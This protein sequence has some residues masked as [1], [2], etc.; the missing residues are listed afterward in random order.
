MTGN[1]SGAGNKH[2][3]AHNE[4]PPPAAAAAEELS[5]ERSAM[6]AASPAAA[7]HSRR[8]F[9]VAKIEVGNKNRGKNVHALQQ[10]RRRVATS[11]CNGCAHVARRLKKEAAG[12]RWLRQQTEAA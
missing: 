1:L 8:S 5:P 12:R 10:R 11:F 3:T 2:I 6:R 4:R 9:K 7:Y